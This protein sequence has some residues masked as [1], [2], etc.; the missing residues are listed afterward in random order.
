[1]RAIAELKSRKDECNRLLHLLRSQGG[2]LGSLLA[3]ELAMAVS[4]YVEPSEQH[5]RVAEHR[6]TAGRWARVASREEEDGEEGE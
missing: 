4:A 2:E 3:G 5:L 6:G 1:M